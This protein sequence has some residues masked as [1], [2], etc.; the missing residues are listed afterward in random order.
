MMNRVKNI[1]I[2]SLLSIVSLNVRGLL[3]MEKFEKVKELCKKTNVILLQETNWKNE[4]MESV[5]RRWK[6]DIYYNNGD[7]EKGKGV[8]VL[9]KR[10]ISDDVKIIYCDTEGKCIIV[11]LVWGGENII[12]CNV[13]APNAEAEKKIFFNNLNDYIEKWEKV[14]LMGDFNTVLSRMDIAKDMVFKRDS[15]RDELLKLIDKNDLIDIWRERNEGIK[16]FSRQQLVKGKMKQSRID[17]MLIKRNM[18]RNIDKIYYKMTSLSDHS[19]LI[20][21][22]NETGLER[23]KGIWCLNNELLKDEN[24][25]LAVEAIITNERGKG[26]F[27]EDK[28]VWWDNVKYE[29]KKYSLRYSR[30]KQKIKRGEEVAV[31]NILKEELQKDNGDIE[32]I[33]INEN[34]LKEIE[35]EKCRGA[36]IRSRAKNVMEGERCTKFFFNLEESRQKADTIKEVLKKDGRR[37]KETKEILQRVKEFYADLFIS[38]GTK[39]D[40][41]QCLL[42]KVKSKV[43]KEDKEMCDKD[44]LEEEIETAIVQL[45]NGKS[46]GADGLTSEFYKVFKDT[47]TPI[48]KEVYEE[49]YERGQ[50]SQ[51]MRVGMV[52]LIFK[53]R[54]DSADLKNYRPI[55][56]LNTDFKIL[57]K[58]LANRL[59]KVLPGL[60]TTNQ[61]YSIMGREITDT[62][63]N[64]RDKISY[65]IENKKEG[66]IISLDLEKAF[67]RV[68]HDYLFELLEH[69]GFGNNFIRWIR[70]LYKGA[71][72]FIK[73]N[74]FLTDVF[75]ITRSIRQGC[76]L[77]SLLYSIV[78]EPLGLVVGEDGNIK[79][80]GFGGIEKEQ[81]I[82]QYADDTTLILKDLDSVERAMNKIQ[83]YCKGSGAKI[84][85][86]KT[87]MMRIG[88]AKPLPDYFSF[89]E[90][91]ENMKILGIRFGKDEKKTR[92]L[93]WDE[94]LGG[95]ERRLTFWR[96]RMLKLRGKILI[97]NA[98]MLSKMW[99]A[100]EVTS[101]PIWVYKRLKKCILHFIWEGKPAKI[102]YDTMI[103]P[104]EEGGLGL[105][106][107]D[108]RMKSLRVKIMKKFL[109]KENR[110]EWKDGMKYFLNRCGG[111]NM[112]NDIIWMKLKE[113]MLNG[114]PELYKEVLRAWKEFLLTVVYKPEGM[115]ELLNQPLFLNSNI[116]YENNEIYFKKWIKAGINKVK[117][118]L[119][120]VKEGF[121]PLQGIVDEIEE[122][123]EE[124][125]KS[126]VKQQFDKIKKAIPDEWIERIEKKEEG[127]GKVEVLLKESGKEVSIQSCSLK[128][129]YKF[130]RKMVF[131]KPIANGF[132]NRLFPVTESE[133][134]WENLRIS[135]MDPV[136]ENF[137]VLLRHNVIYTKMRLCKMGIEQNARCDVC[138]NE[139]EGLL[140]LFLFCSE[141]EDFVRKFKMFIE[142][143]LGEQ[144]ES[145]MEWNQVFLLGIKG[146]GKEMFIVNFILSIAR[147]AIWCRRNVMREKSVNINMW[148]FFRR[149]LEGH[150]QTLYNYFSMNRQVE[151]FYKY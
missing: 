29:I 117:D 36:M 138:E 25:K 118:V 104:I 136:I 77:S 71:I 110:Q 4:M 16:D 42:E 141:L 134:I 14:I 56:M 21:H 5:K 12:L 133:N 26:M 9:F 109:N 35:E 10:N 88:T 81:K 46:P 59:K 38:E 132:W 82:Y 78:A 130:F 146:K 97:V 99:Y 30:L 96:Q 98:L 119:Y 47:L 44:F 114:V 85:I 101:L 45:N 122:I 102:A 20:V 51:L 57:A 139:D 11:R 87:V 22:F 7:G 94:I 105:L 92:D 90:E 151:R 23:G 89:K 31:R 115:E 13:H 40:E 1:L 72:S 6:G 83:K 124:V 135:Y 28:R 54:G 148:S 27:E 75:S 66:Y 108:I 76:P 70:V 84:N 93:I 95:M 43:V 68:E 145:Q 2:I 103:G 32:T 144:I 129:I 49:I 33:I 137:N 107:P 37:V 120:E 3:N 149:K 50:A 142:A 140:H 48:L 67:D 128:M 126:I 74:G 86:D 111:F 147:Y 63:S 100:L 60:I 106:D 64:I 24:Y 62:V 8:A 123:G 19:M 91:T 17:F 150:I 18:T 113:N 127:E 116:V 52:K 69:F 112:G 79:G 143:F 131:A 34:R 61:A 39:E 80:I 53:K 58:M 55:S 125:D 41:K 121:I 65:M 73:C 15:G